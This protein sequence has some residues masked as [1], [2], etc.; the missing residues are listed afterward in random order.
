MS[1]MKQI[2]ELLALEGAFGHSW[3]TSF[4]V[5]A[6]VFSSDSQGLF[7]FVHKVFSEQL[8]KKTA[9]VHLH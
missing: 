9:T 8:L 4:A 6:L 7:K 3:K 2:L 5:T 1:N